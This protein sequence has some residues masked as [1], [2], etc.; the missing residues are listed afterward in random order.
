MSSGVTSPPLCNVTLVAVTPVIPYL[1]VQCLFTVKRTRK[2]KELVKGRCDSN[3]LP[4]LWNSNN[5]TVKS[6]VRSLTMRFVYLILSFSK[7]LQ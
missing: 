3:S 5:H 7:H 1:T 4:L 6:T 2:R